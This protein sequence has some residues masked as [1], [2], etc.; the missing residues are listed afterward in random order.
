MLGLARQFG[1]HRTTVMAVLDRKRVARRS[2]GRVLSLEEIERASELYREGFTL[3]AVGSELGVD[4]RVIRRG[5]LAAGV[6]I[7][8]AGAP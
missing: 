3:R 7:R 4:Y 5:L 2:A 6:R 1:V 8:R